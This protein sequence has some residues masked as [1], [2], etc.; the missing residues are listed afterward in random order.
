[1]NL[2]GLKDYVW[3]RA[4]LGKVMVGRHVMDD[5]VH[6]TVE[7]WECEHLNACVEE[8]SRRAV[9]AS[10]LASVKR[11]HQVTSGK[12]TQEYGFIWAFLLQM[13]A[14]AVIQII[15]RYWQERASNRVWIV[16]MKAELTR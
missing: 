11:G 10:M 6:L 9:C 14:A 15:L 4:P 8:A 12:E 7:N 3:R 13:L 1:M 16:A 5:F 2:D